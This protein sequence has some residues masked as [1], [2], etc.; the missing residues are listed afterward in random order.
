MLEDTPTPETDEPT[1]GEAGSAQP[2]LPAERPIEEPP[3]AQ[4]PAPVERTPR[5]TAKK[6]TTKKAATKKAATKKAAAKTG[7]QPATAA[8]PDAEATAEELPDSAGET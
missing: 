1:I 8:E 2:E 3:A 5:K 7:S 6:A 4:D